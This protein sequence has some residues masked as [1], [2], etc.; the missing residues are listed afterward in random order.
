[1]VSKAYGAIAANPVLGMLSD[2][3]DEDPGSDFSMH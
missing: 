2:A 1:M 3:F